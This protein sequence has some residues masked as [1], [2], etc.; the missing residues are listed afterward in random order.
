MEKHALPLTAD[1]E[2]AVEPQDGHLKHLHLGELP[3]K[4]LST[5][6]SNP[7]GPYQPRSS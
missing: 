6:L 2:A 4:G 5:A 1:T 3:P 7:R